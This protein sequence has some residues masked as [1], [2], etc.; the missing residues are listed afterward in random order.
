MLG[1]EEKRGADQRVPITCAQIAIIPRNSV[2]EARAAASSIMVRNDMGKP[3]LAEQTKNIV[4]FMF[5][6]QAPVAV[7]VMKVTKYLKAT[8]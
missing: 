2:S 7:F 1:R 5:S 8:P 6:C 4:P 3:L